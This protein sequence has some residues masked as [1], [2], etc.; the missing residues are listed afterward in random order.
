MGMGFTDVIRSWMLSEEGY[1]VWYRRRISN[2][3]RA[4]INHSLRRHSYTFARLSERLFFAMIT[5]ACDL[6]GL[7]FLST[8]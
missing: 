5:I 2:A 4:G 7:C 6:R 3:F 8:R 1:G